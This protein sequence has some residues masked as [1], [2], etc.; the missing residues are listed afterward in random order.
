[1]EF[2]HMNKNIILQRNMKM[3]TFHIVCNIIN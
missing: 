2:K 3:T 1:M